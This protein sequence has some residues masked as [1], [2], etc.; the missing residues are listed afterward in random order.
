MD[1]DDHR[2]QFDG[3]VDDA[4]NRIM[5]VLGD[6]SIDSVKDPMVILETNYSEAYQG[7]HFD[8]FRSGNSTRWNWE[9]GATCP[10][11]NA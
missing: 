6:M 2:R 4:R 11:E 3:A 10:V 5:A 8:V 7:L 1:Q 9:I